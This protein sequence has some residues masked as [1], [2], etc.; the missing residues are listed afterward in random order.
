MT[1]TNQGPV[2]VFDMVGVDVADLD[3]SARFWMALLGVEVDHRL[4]AYIFF[5]KQGD[6][7]GLYL[8]RVPEKKTTKTRVHVDVA[9]ENLDTAVARAV[10]LGAKKVQS[11]VEGAD[12]HVVMEDPDGNEFCLTHL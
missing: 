3:R 11:F 8:Q 2:G 4:D 6:G 5:K 10:S 12:G 1:S 9:V 7:P